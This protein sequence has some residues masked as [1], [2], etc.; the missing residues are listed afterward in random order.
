M[1]T[2]VGNLLAWLKK[3]DWPHTADI[4]AAFDVLFVNS[5]VIPRSVVKRVKSAQPSV[6]VLQRVDG[7]AIDYGSDPANDRIQ[8]RVNLLADVTVFQSDYSK[9]STRQ[10][11]PVIWQDGPVIYNP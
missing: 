4:E 10:K 6:R 5:W 2:F 9:Y 8:A 11:F 7:A 1:Y 3:V